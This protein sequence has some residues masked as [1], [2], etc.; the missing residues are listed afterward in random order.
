MG[1]QYLCS[2][3]RFLQNSRER[4]KIHDSSSQDKFSHV[5]FSKKLSLILLLDKFEHI[6][7]RGKGYALIEC[8]LA[9]RSTYCE[10]Q[11]YIGL[12]KKSQPCS[13]IQGSRLSGQFFG[14]YTLEMKVIWE[15]MQDEVFYEFIRMCRQ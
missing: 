2:Q 13:V 9:G 15:I 5:K 11:G 12:F 6:G 3:Y 8:F 10:V 14:I 7:I 1:Q 4:L